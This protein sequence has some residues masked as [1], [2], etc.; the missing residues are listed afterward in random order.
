VA[1]LVAQGLTNQE[2]ARRLVVAPRTAETHIENIL[3][4]LGFRSRAQIASWTTAQN[5]SPET[6]LRS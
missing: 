5:S 2:I 6:S 4:K 1:A 3:Q